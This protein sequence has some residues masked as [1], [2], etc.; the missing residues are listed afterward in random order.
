MA[1]FTV[2]GGFVLKIKAGQKYAEKMYD[3]YLRY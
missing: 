2:F 3:Q 1:L